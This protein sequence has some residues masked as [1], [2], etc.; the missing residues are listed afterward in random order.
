MVMLDM[1]LV[2]V[3][4]GMIMSEMLVI[5][6]ETMVMKYNGDYHC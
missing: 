6:D 5:T 4:A 3:M 2:N 1:H